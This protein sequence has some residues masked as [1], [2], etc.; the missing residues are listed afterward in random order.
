MAYLAKEDFINAEKD[1]TKVIEIDPDY[2]NSYLERA[3][4]LVEQR[5]F[6]DAISDLDQAISLYH[7]VLSDWD[8]SKVLCN[9]AILLW[10]RH[11]VDKSLESLEEALH[12]DQTTFL[13]WYYKWLILSQEHQ[14]YENA[15]SCFD[16]AVKYGL[17]TRDIY[18]NRAEIKQKLWD[19]QWSEK[20]LEKAGE[21][22]V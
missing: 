13:A 2:S 19:L 1:F 21:L 12:H 5:R 11:E 3:K 16:K 14:A 22:E 9:K 7:S 6:K 17:H 4:T 8:I 20:D 10:D 15:L 18:I